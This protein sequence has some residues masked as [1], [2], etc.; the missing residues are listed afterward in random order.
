MKSKFFL[1]LNILFLPTV[2]LLAQNRVNFHQSNGKVRS[3]HFDDVD[4]VSFQ[5]N[6]SVAQ[7]L[8]SSSLQ[9]DYSISL[10][11]SLTFLND[12]SNTES[13]LSAY[14]RD[15]SFSDS[16]DNQYNELEEFIVTDPEDNDYNDF[17]ENYPIEGTITI[18]YNGSSATVSGSYKFVEVKTNGAHVTVMSAQKKMNYIL[19]GSTQN[20]SFKIYSDNKF[21]LELSGLDITNPRGPALNIQTGKSVYIYLKPGTTNNLTDGLIYDSNP[22]ED[23]KGA[24]FSEG[25]LLI[26][27]LGSLNVTSLSAHG[28]C[29]DDYIRIRQGT[30]DITVNAFRDGISTN[31]YFLMYGG[32]LN[33]TAGDDGIDVNKGKVNIMGGRL[34]VNSFDDAVCATYGTNDTTS[35]SIA[36]GLIKLYTSGNKGHGLITSGVM[37][38][39]GGVIQ[40]TTNGDASKAIKCDQNINIDGSR[41]TMMVNGDPFFNEDVLDY[42]SSAGIR[43]LKSLS[44]K[45]SIIGIKNSGVGG[46]GINVAGDISINNSDITVITTGESLYSDHGNV[47]PRGIDGINIDLSEGINAFIRSSHNAIY[48]ESDL[49]IGASEIYSFTTSTTAKS[50]NVKG[51]ISQTDGL[52]LFGATD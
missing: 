20:G 23:Q 44:I 28:I 21:K 46:K 9:A 51:V 35:I 33:L 26:S 39:T 48:A 36:G 14:S 49:K 30:G 19:K 5:N 34:T 52:L 42:S 31:D 50:V 8:F 37:N 45:N 22:Y 38:L 18:T 15:V 27:G 12:L 43:C 13:F 47:R 11:D 7:F 4:L 16:D 6:N 41:L 2:L 40:I 1:L 29:S 24:L 25:Q 3:V 32:N 17:I 10:L